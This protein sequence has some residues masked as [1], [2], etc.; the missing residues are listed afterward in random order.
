MGD[1]WR[2]CVEEKAYEN[3]ID[4]VGHRYGMLTV[5]A[6][7]PS[8]G[9]GARWL[10]RCD[11]GNTVAVNGGALRAGQRKSCG[12]Q[13]SRNIKMVG[14]RFGRLVV[15]KDIVPNRALCRCGCGRMLVL[16]KGS[17]RRGTRSCGCLRKGA[18]VKDLTGKRYGR[19]T[20]VRI[21]ENSPTPSDRA[22]WV[23]RCDCGTELV[24]ASS[25]LTS[26]HTK[27]CGCLARERSG[28]SRRTIETGN[29]YGR[30]TVISSAVPD[31]H[32]ARWLCRCDCGNTTVVRGS[33]L[34]SR[35]SKSCGCLR[36][37]R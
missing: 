7:A 12:C 6:P 26:G 29:R 4:E 16:P 35:H 2:K 15:T 24:V 18:H 11:C 27:S 37:R 32:G 22:Q 21:E 34:R 8:L 25:S 19:L 33:S 17:L 31:G 10:C 30:L 5:L 13:W 23:C 20:V 36:K 1:W 14:Q 28:L 9:Q 3:T